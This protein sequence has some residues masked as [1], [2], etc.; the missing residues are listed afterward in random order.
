LQEKFIS[1]MHVIDSLAPGGA[2]R[3]LLDIV[4]N[5]DIEKYR[6]SVCITRSNQALSSELHS[7]IPFITLGRKWRFDPEGFT[8]FKQFSD[9]QDVDVYH[10]HGRSSYSFVLLARLLGFCKAPIVFHDHYGSL[11]IDNSV[12]LWFKVF[13]AGALAHYIGVC[14][15]LASWAA[16]A[17]VPEEKITVVGNGLDLSRFEKIK[18]LNLHSLVNIPVDK[19]IGIVVGTIRADKGLDLLIDACMHFNHEDMP[20]FVIVGTEF[21]DDF[22]RTCKNKLK[23]AGLE[24]YF[25][26]AG[27]QE[28]AL[29]WIKGADFAVMPARSESGPLVLIE[30]ML[31]EVPFVAFNVGWVSNLVQKYLPDNFADPGEIEQLYSRIMACLVIT[32]EEMKNRIKRGKKFAEELFDIKDRIPLITDIYQKILNPQR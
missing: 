16:D 24:S 32:P 12:P 18:A 1:V 21:D 7:D 10:V 28:N 30:Y 8:G 27:I 15:G 9:Q 13:G 23:G 5:L 22:N 31:C 20:Y 29:A 11:H 26:F 2:D 3:M 6:V 25:K 4:N 19:P 14:E 17:G